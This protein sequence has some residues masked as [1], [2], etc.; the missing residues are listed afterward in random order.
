MSMANAERTFAGKGYEEELQYLS[1]LIRHRVDYPSISHSLKRPRIM[2]VSWHFVTIL[3]VD[4]DFLAL[5]F[6][7]TFIA[8]HSMFWMLRHGQSRA[9]GIVCEVWICDHV[10]CKFFPAKL[11]SVSIKILPAPTQYI[12][13]RFASFSWASPASNRR[14]CILRLFTSQGS[15]IKVTNSLCNSKYYYWQSME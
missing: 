3:W 6:P 10:Y 7:L 14:Y 5:S 12:L 9:Q 8:L 15:P 2:S 1:D 4:D 11:L 13:D